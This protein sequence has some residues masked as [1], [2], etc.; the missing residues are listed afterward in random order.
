MYERIL[1]PLDGST[2]AESVL[3]NVEDLVI[4]MAPTT[5]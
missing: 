4:R 2:V 5:V 1:V 3:T